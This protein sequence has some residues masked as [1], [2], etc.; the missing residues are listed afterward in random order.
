[1]N[2]NFYQILADGVLAAHFGLVLF[3]IGGLI[4]ILLGGRYRWPWV[5]NFWFRVAHLCAIG[6]VVAESW[7]GVVCPLTSLEQL[8]R[9]RAGQLTYEGD[10][11]T[12]WL[13]NLVF[14]QA[15]PW[16]FIAAYSLFALLVIGSWVIVR[17]APRR[18]K[19]T[20]DTAAS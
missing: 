5:R 6:Y 14:Y 17:P 15:P 13:G 16:V 19:E 8:L 2:S 3:I 12:H 11:I 10:F 20:V 1:M 9:E 18:S 7:L 4:L